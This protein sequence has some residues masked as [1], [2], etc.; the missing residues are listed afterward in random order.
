MMRIETRGVR[1]GEWLGDVPDD[2]D[3]EGFYE[4]YLR[5][6]DPYKKD[7]DRAVEV[8]KKLD[9]ALRGGLKVQAIETGGFT[10][11]VYKCGLYDGWPF[12]IPRPCY[13][14]YRPNRKSISREFYDLYDLKIGERLC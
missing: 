1:V 8:F 13:A 2:W 14:Y 4:R 3:Y 11:E 12:W 6:C 7:Y 5:A 10:Y 9:L